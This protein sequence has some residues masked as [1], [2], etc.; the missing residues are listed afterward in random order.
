VRDL[1]HKHRRGS[2]GA[3]APR[4]SSRFDPG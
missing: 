3:K 4:L 2:T 1:V